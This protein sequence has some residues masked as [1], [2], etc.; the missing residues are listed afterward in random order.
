MR[1][2]EFRPRPPVPPR[3]LEITARIGPPA[4]RR[5]IFLLV[6]GN[7]GGKRASQFPRHRFVAVARR[8]R[9]FQ[10]ANSYDPASRR[11]GHRIGPVDQNVPRR[12]TIDSY[13][14]CRARPS[15]LLPPPRWT[16]RPSS[17][18]VERELKIADMTKEL[19]VSSAPFIRCHPLYTTSTEIHDGQSVSVPI[20]VSLN[21][22]TPEARKP[23]ATRRRFI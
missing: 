21:L 14:Q 15:Q 4:N 8:R 12:V 16:N 13:A 17:I 9:R 5:E 2:Y 7:L 18:L 10:A 20:S 3:P 23:S 19:Y 1:D 6:N 11:S 22:S